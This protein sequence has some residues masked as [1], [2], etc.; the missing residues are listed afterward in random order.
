MKVLFYGRP[1]L[2]GKGGITVKKIYFNLSNGTVVNHYSSLP[3]YYALV[4]KGKVKEI[5]ACFSVSNIAT[6][7]YDWLQE[8]LDREVK[9]WDEYN[10][11][12]KNQLNRHVRKSEFW[13]KDT[14]FVEQNYNRFIYIR[15]Y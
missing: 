13:F 14:N 5:Y 7:G 4:S 8:R 15:F 3:P 9:I 12:L 11:D 6:H 1:K 2:C 10:P